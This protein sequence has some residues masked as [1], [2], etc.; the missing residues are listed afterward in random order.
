VVVA[1]HNPRYVATFIILLCKREHQSSSRGTHIL[2]R[3]KEKEIE[4]DSRL[5]VDKLELLS[6]GFCTFSAIRQSNCES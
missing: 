1:L 2:E 3:E 4:M 6:L 5:E